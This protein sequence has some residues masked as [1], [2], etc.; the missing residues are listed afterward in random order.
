MTAKS[1]QLCP[2]LCDPIDGSPPGSPIY[3]IL[4]A[5]TLEWVGIS[6][7]NAW[8]WK[9]SCSVV[10]DPQR[11]HGL[12]PSRLLHPWDFPGKSTRVGCHC[13]LPSLW[14]VISNHWKLYGA[15]MPK[16]MFISFYFIALFLF[17]EVP[18]TKPRRKCGVFWF[19][20]FL[21]LIVLVFY[22]SFC[23]AQLVIN[24]Y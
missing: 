16:P 6:F 2:T 10:S 14:Q 13:L 12:Q 17:S 19:S 20:L 21:D 5:R 7:S 11:P 23:M 3:G 9:W 4:Q 24:S 15:R 22:P 8:K 1:L 18:W